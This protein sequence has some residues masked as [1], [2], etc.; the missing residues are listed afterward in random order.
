MAKKISE[1]DDN[2]ISLKG[3]EYFE[4]VQNGGSVKA[5]LSEI[6]LMMD[7]NIQ[8]WNIV[9]DGASSWKFNET[10]SQTPPAL[11][12][13][14]CRLRIY[15]TDQ[16]LN[17]VGLISLGTLNIPTSWDGHLV[18]FYLFTN[19]VE[20]GNT[21]LRV[22]LKS[23]KLIMVG[24]GYFPVYY[25]QSIYFR[26]QSMI[27]I[28]ECYDHGL[29]PTI[30]E[31]TKAFHQLTS[32]GGI[33]LELSQYASVVASNMDVFSNLSFGQQ[34]LTGTTMCAWADNGSGVQQVMGYPFSSWSQIL[35]MTVIQNRALDETY[36]NITVP[37]DPS[38]ILTAL[39]AEGGSGS[40]PFWYCIVEPNDFNKTLSIEL[41]N[42][43]TFIDGTTTL[44]F[45]N[46]WGYWAFSL[47]ESGANKKVINHNLIGNI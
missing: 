44:D 30:Y 5:Q 2:S 3:D 45:G 18:E 33:N 39:L 14:P 11:L 27:F 29:P 15:M 4:I 20:N 32:T 28:K 40:Y 7:S 26:N 8:T 42:G 16:N 41:Q 9:S 10:D 24:S 34:R 23:N 37:F 47:Y 22:G 46:N 21:R 13:T 38:E 31:L 1:M 36:L 12:D 17:N 25:S 35:G 43:W 6:P 19:I